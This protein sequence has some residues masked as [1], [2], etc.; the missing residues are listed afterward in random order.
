M[1]IIRDFIDSLNYGKRKEFMRMRTER[2]VEIIEKTKDDLINLFPNDTVSVYNNGRDA[3]SVSVSFP[4]LMSK[5]DIFR[6]AYGVAAYPPPIQHQSLLDFDIQ[7]GVDGAITLSFW[8]NKNWIIETEK[9]FFEK[10][11]HERRFE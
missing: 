7:C 1:D 8:P 4:H 6:L 3:I 10:K 9:M 5:R 11:M 2:A